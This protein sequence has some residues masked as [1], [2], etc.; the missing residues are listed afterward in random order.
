MDLIKQS[1]AK[2][3]QDI[4][5]LKKEFF[6]LKQGV[7][8]TR[9]QMIEICEILQKIT[10]KNKEIE[11]KLKQSSSTHNPQNITNS[12]H[13]ST[14]NF[15]FKPLKHQIL[16]ISTGNQGVSTD[17]QTDR[18]THNQ[19]QNHQKIQKNSVDNVS[20]ILNSLDSIKKEVRLKFKSLTEQEMLIF[21]AI[22]QLDEEKGYSD[23]KMLSKKLN[24]T[25]SSIRDYVRR[26]IKK[27]I[28][29]EKNR[30]NNKTI[31]LKISENLKKI[32]SLPTIMQLRDL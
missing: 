27:G 1:F 23:Y 2:V 3:K 10:L 6:S 22:Y 18:Q 7:I 21:S 9:E 14:D 31:Q 24:L 5:F 17:R 29:V 28:S 32:A 15:L 26:L 12:T 30:I 13:I 25:E 11:K 4:D 8:E 16:P 19:T 20:E